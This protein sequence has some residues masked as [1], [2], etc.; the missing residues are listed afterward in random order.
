ML[1]L[2]AR[3]V[4]YVGDA[5]FCGVVAA[6]EVAGEAKC[7]PDLESWVRV[8]PLADGVE[9]GDPLPE[10]LRAVMLID[11][12]WVWVPPAAVAGPQH[13]HEGW[14]DGI[15]EGAKIP[16]CWSTNSAM[17]TGCLWPMRCTTSLVPAKTPR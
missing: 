11:P 6:A 4:G 5:A 16:R 1:P 17:V 9:G 13:G 8:V 7:R 14:L 3:G 2:Q 10:R 15:A 12:L